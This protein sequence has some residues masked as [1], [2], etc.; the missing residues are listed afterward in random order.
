[1][2]AHLAQ[3]YG[4]NDTDAFFTTGLFSMVDQLVDAPM[5]QVLS[6]VPLAEEITAA[7][8]NYQGVKGEALRAAIMWEQ[9]NSSELIVPPG[10]TAGMMGDVYRESVC[11]AGATVA[12]NW[13]Y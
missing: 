12:G 1:M 5:V 3:A 11:W 6:S 4:D 8:L 13:A 10:M 7:I 2:C 9:V